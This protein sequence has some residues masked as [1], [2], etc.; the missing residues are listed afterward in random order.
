MAQYQKIMISNLLSALPHE[1]KT[2]G[3]LI[4]IGLPMAIVFAGEFLLYLEKK[5]SNFTPIVYNIRNILLPI[6]T[7]NIILSKIIKLGDNSIILKISDTFFWLILIISTLKLVNIFVFSDVLPKQTQEK[8]PKLL[9]DFGR[10]FLILLGAAIIA[11]NVW[12]ADLGR[13][14]AALGVGSIVLGLALQDVLG[15]LFSG[16]LALEIG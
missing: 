8:I 5:E 6:L 7:V 1:W 11:S 13:L 12:G 2:W 4:I 15:G 14:L 9:V 3:L 10:T 16:D